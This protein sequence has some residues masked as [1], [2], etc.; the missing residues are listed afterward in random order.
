MADLLKVDAEA[1]S[2]RIISAAAATTEDEDEAVSSLKRRKSSTLDGDSGS[3]SSS[4][5]MYEDPVD[6]LAGAAAEKINAGGSSDPRKR[7]EPVL[8]N[9]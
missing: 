2:S 7:K 5:H 8:M 9:S 6:D 3:S 1:E 4:L